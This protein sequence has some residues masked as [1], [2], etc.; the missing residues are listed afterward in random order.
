MT[1]KRRPQGCLWLGILSC[2]GVIDFNFVFYY[3]WMLAHPLYDD[4]PKWQWLLAA[5]LIILAIIA[6][7]WVRV[8]LRLYPDDAQERPHLR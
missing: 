8:L 7:V 5:S 2:I 3:L 4:N 1:V 6:A